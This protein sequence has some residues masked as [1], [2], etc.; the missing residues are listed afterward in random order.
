M[1]AFGSEVEDFDALDASGH[2]RIGQVQGVGRRCAGRGDRGVQVVGQQAVD[3]VQG[4]IGQ[5]G[6]TDFVENGVQA[7][8]RQD[9]A[10]RN[11][12]VDQRGQQGIGCRA[13]NQAFDRSQGG[14]AEHGR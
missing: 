4:H 7:V 6:R 3:V 8:R 10:I 14:G 2:Q 9:D 1:L 12:F 13:V 5:C 11:Q